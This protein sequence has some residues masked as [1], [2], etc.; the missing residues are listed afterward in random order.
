MSSDSILR[1]LWTRLHQEAGKS[2]PTGQSDAVQTTFLKLLENEAGRAKLVEMGPDLSAMTKTTL[3]RVQ[4]D[5]WRYDNAE[6]RVGTESLGETDPVAD[7][8]PTV[9]RV[10]K[11][12]LSE[13]VRRA[14]DQMDGS[15]RDVIKLE[16]YAGL[17]K[18]QIAEALQI[19]R[20]T[21]TLRM[22]EGLAALCSSLIQFIE[23]ES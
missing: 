18:T 23:E 7:E 9:E 20:N 3:G 10:I 21:V 16:F 17:S 1:A 15:L 6:M 5:R 2:T 22:N 4:I 14:I 12:E 19:H 8:T 11:R 13:Y